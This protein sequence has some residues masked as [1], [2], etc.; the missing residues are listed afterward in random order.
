MGGEKVKATAKTRGTADSSASL[1]ND[2]QKTDN[3]KGGGFGA[4]MSYIYPT[5]RKKRARMGHPAVVR[6]E[7]RTGN[8]KSNGN[9][10]SQCGGSSLRSE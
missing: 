2:K 5:L 1:R 9:C 7:R 4:L 10:K 3:G 6:E 8:G